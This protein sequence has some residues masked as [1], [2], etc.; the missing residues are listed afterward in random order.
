M[1]ASTFNT[2]DNI[3][4]TEAKLPPQGPRD[5]DVPHASRERLFE[6]AEGLNVPLLESN[7]DTHP[8]GELLAL[9]EM[10]H[11]PIRRWGSDVVGNL[12]IG[13]GGTD[14]N[15]TNEKMAFDNA[16]IIAYALVRAG[17]EE[18]GKEIPGAQRPPEWYMWMRDEPEQSIPDM[19][20]ALNERQHKLLEEYPDYY[21]ALQRWAMHR[22]PGFGS[23][24]TVGA[25]GIAAAEM[26]YAFEKTEETASLERMFDQ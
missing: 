26:Y 13:F 10:E 1:L 24:Y 18:A 17:Y 6:I 3:G 5:F 4:M 11:S 2:K 16:F 20:Q 21:E 15:L 14:E 9:M 22:V 19:F 25:V 8:M 12:N 23:G 7:Q